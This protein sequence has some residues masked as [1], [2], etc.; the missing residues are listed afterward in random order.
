ME[1]NREQPRQQFDVGFERIDYQLTRYAAKYGLIALRVSIGVIFF[2]FG[3]LKLFPGL[4][5]A[6][7]LI[8]ETMPAWVPMDLF[9]PF[10]AIWEI[11]IGLG[12]IIGGKLLRHTILLMLLHMPG[13]ASPLVLNPDAVWTVFPFGLTLEGQYIIKNLIL[14][15]AA[16][17]VGAVV[18]GGYISNEPSRDE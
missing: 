14:V 1:L 6:E 7:G 5:P 18:R 12:F 13:T 10:L 9:Y 3:A 4:S 11:V 16:V 2:W 8:F 15:S 17:V